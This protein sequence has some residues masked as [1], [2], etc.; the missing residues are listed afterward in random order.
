MGAETEGRPVPYE[1]AVASMFEKLGPC[2]IM[3]VGACAGGRVTVRNVSGIFREGRIFFKTDVNFP[4][5]RQLL[6]NPKTA[7]CVGGV[8]VEGDAVN[9]GKVTD[10]PG[11]VFERLYKEYWD[12]SYTAYPH[13]ETEILMEV[14]PSFAEIWDQDENFKGFQTFIDFERKE[15]AV[16]Y[17][18]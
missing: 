2:K 18:D 13:T 1:E 5:T 16:K 15:A 10:E 6:E 11:R 12:K 3:A 9:L 8:Q 17:Y 14:V 7:I 4:K